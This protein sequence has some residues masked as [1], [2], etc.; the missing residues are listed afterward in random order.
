MS[1]NQTSPALLA[2]LEVA[3]YR[4]RVERAIAIAVEAFDWNCPQHITRRFT[5]DEVQRL[6]EP[7]ARRIE[8]LEAE[9]AADIIL[10]PRSEGPRGERPRDPRAGQAP[11]RRRTASSVV[12]TAL[13][14]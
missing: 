12:Q 14:R 9:P 7:F 1:C 13:A 4:A 11:V 6:T 5:L 8:D 10:F 3:D 2:R